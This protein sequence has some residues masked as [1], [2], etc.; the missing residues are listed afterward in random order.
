VVNELY[1]RQNRLR[2]FEFV[3]QVEV[4][5]KVK[6]TIFNSLTSARGTMTLL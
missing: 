6:F 3:S 2:E 4:V 5:F 1:Q